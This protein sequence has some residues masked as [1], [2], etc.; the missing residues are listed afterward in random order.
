MIGPLQFAQHEV[1]DPA[2][3][4]VLAAAPAVAQDVGVLALVQQVDD[5]HPA[6]YGF[7]Q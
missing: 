1:H 5:T 7:P 2:A 3:A 6:G 4:N